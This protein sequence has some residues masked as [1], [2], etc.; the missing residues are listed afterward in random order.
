[1]RVFVAIE[2]KEP[3]IL[4]SIKK[5]QTEF[6]ESV[7]NPKNIKLV[8]TDIVHFTLQFLGE[9]PNTAQA[10]ITKALLSIKFAPF[11]LK[12]R[13]VGAFPNSKHPKIVWVGTDAMKDEKMDSGHNN[14]DSDTVNNNNNDNSTIT[15]HN[16]E[17]PELAQK[18]TDVLNPLGYKRDKPFKPHS[19]IFRIKMR[20]QPPITERLDRLTNKTF[21][22]QRVESLKFKK[23]QL[24]P[25]GPIYTDLAIIKA[26]GDI[27]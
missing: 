6:V 26:N 3:S 16:T 27:K 10:S 2:I 5:L 24:T 17:M 7:S 21:G 19:T 11:D 14:Y 8:N 23:S 22:I 4:D 9:I 12:I 1:M 18:V 13:G 20:V 25:S 15:K